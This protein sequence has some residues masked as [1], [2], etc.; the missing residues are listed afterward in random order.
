M[1]FC[2]LLL[3][4]VTACNYD[5]EN[6][7]KIQD[8]SPDQYVK[9]V[10]N[11]FFSPE[12]LDT[13]DF[14]KINSTLGFLAKKYAGYPSSLTGKPSVYLLINDIK[15][16]LAG[17][18]S[19]LPTLI[20]G[21][22]REQGVYVAN[23]DS[24]KWIRTGNATD[25]IVMYFKDQYNQQR[26]A[27]MAWYYSYGAPLPITLVRSTGN[28]TLN[29]P[30]KIMVQMRN[31]SSENDS[32]MTVH[33]A[34]VPV[35]GFS[36]IKLVTTAT[37]LSY[38]LSA[39]A[40][41]KDTA[42]HINAS[43]TKNSKEIAS[44]KLDGT[45]TDLIRGLIDKVDYTL[46]LGAYDSRLNILNKL[47]TTNNVKDANTLKTYILANSGSGTYEYVKN[48]CDIVNANM[49]FRVWNSSGDLLC[50]ATIFP[51]KL[52]GTYTGAPYVNWIYGDSQDLS[53]FSSTAIKNVVTKLQKILQ[54]LNGMLGQT[55]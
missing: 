11:E 14:K 34:M 29:L 55:A 30:D 1:I 4:I 15:E 10:A 43:M 36:E 21:F 28:V 7:Q 22:S 40:D 17:K 6:A 12:N 48:I 26:Q 38:A 45:G 19:V 41:V 5:T 27:I 23:T 54:Y 13:M 39:V 53:D 2:L 16:I 24:Q 51:V 50:S 9:N 3:F 49:Y 33:V 8:V 35:Q 25:S 42:M 37:Y 31:L 44:Y 47:Y 20:N 32:A 18:T 46:T 52:N